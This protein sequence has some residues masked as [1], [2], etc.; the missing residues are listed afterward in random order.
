MWLRRAWDLRRQRADVLVPAYFSCCL[1]RRVVDGEG[2]AGR[3]GLE[4]VHEHGCD[5]P[6]CDACAPLALCCFVS[7]ELQEYRFERSDGVGASRRQWTFY[8]GSTVTD[9]NSDAAIRAIV[10]PCS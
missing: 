10:I 4:G 8:N 5:H 7:A 2:G 6:S 9:S 3:G 1:E